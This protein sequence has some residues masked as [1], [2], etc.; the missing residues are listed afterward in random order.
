[1]CRPPRNTW[2]PHRDIPQAKGLAEKQDPKLLEE[3]VDVMEVSPP[4]RT[5]SVL[6]C[7]DKSMLHPYP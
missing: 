6:M 1:M 5:M 7:K 3:L 4:T 2:Q